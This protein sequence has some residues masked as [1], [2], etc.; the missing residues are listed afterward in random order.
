MRANQESGIDID[1]FFGLETQ[2]WDTLIS[3]D[4][5]AD[6][7]LLAD[8]FLGVYSTGFA[9]KNEHVGQL[10]AGPV[11]KSYSLSQARIQS[12]CEDVVLLSYKAQWV[13]VRATP[14]DAQELMYISSVWRRREGVW[15]NVF[16]QDTIA[17]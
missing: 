13:R 10:A 15:R 4:G 16:S 17:E 2:V 12:L 11:A 5:V 6:E 9:E 8:D 3:G 14:S 7:R 1:F